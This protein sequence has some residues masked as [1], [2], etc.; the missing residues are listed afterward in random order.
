MKPS[1]KDPKHRFFY[2]NKQMEKKIWIDLTKAGLRETTSDLER[3]T[4]Q[5]AQTAVKNAK[6]LSNLQK[7]NL[8]TARTATE[9]RKVSKFLV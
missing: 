1:Y 7:A 2:A 6:F 8:Y 5:R 4:K 3:C 9:K